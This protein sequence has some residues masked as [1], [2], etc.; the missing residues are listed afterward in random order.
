MIA[1]VVSYH[2]DIERLQ[3]QLQ[4]LRHQCA[5]AIVVD[6]GSPAEV[7]GALQ[8]MRQA[9]GGWLEVLPLGT[10]CGV[11][12]A[13]NRGIEHAR[14][15]GASHVLLMD[16]D[17]LPAPD[18]VARLLVGFADAAG[19]PVAAVGPCIHDPRT[20]T[21]LDFLRRGRAGY[22]RIQV[23]QHPRGVLEVAHLISSGSLLA[24][25]ALSQIG[26]LED[27]LFIDAIDTEW[28]LR[29]RAAGFRLRANTAAVLEH[30]LGLRS[31]RLGSRRWGRTIAFHPPFRVYYMFRNNVL[32]CRRKID[33]RW[34]IHISKA[35]LRLTLLYLL[36]LRQ[37][38]CYLR[39]IRHGLAD[40]WRGRSGAMP[41]LLAARLEHCTAG[42]G[43]SA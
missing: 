20:G 34:K 39:A 35:L 17:S 22:E 32:L 33:R 38:R 19:Q 16:Q 9:S 30:E 28:C 27:E 2:P 37:P 1:V 6:N 31:L 5:A 40:G 29:A 14:A 41:D 21:D 13:H 8:A 10:N 7:V 11:A 18:M 4:S 3:Q 24:V 25:N 23:A 36:S 42:S 43:R 12:H 15:G 26:G